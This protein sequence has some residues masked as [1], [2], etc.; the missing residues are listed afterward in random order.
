MSPGG[1][2]MTPF[3][4][5]VSLFAPSPGAEYREKDRP[6]QSSERIVMPQKDREM[7]Q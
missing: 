4:D 5:V 3:G 6:R 2:N 1:V 7:R